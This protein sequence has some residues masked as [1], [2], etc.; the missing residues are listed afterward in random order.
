MPQ[1][2]GAR[3]LG[4]ALLWHCAQGD[5]D[6]VFPVLYASNPVARHVACPVPAG[7]PTVCQLAAHEANNMSLQFLITTLPASGALYET[8]QNFRTYGTD[9]KY[10]PIPIQEHELPFRVGDVLSRVVYVPPSDVFPPEGRWGAFSYTVQEAS[11]GSMS[12]PGQVSLSSPAHHVAA[13]T[14]IS[15]TDAWTIS[16]NIHSTTPTWQAFGWGLLNRYIYGEDEVQYIDFDTGS[17]RSKWYFEAP[18]GKYYLPELAAAYGG[19]IRFTI[20]STYGDFTHL[21]SPLDFITLDCASCNSGRGL[22]IVRYADNGLEWDG[23]ERVIEV[24]VKVGHFWQRDPLSLALPFTVATECE[25]AAVLAG[26][27]RV[28]IL[29]DFTRAGEGIALDDVSISSSSVQP[30]FPLA[31]LQGCVC[32]HD[33]RA[34]RV[35]CCGSDPSIYHP[36]T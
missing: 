21:N 10:A 1:S 24:P 31:C 26:L 2:A 4:L 14:Y 34:R 35:S 8:S 25:I 33:P 6:N 9:P 16:G 7:M 22:R 19:S 17:D 36:I 11:T 13:S 5:V 32:A 30:M 27:T 29:G 3:L 15:G 12:Q 28:R 20:A 23:S 18:P